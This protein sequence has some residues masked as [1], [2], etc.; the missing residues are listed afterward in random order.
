M[1]NKEAIEYLKWIR[2]I[3]PYSLDKIK[4]QESIDLAIKVLETGEVYMTGEDYNLYM[5]GYKAGKNDFGPKQG[6]WIDTG[7]G[8]EC[9]VCHEIQYGYDN[10]RYFCANCGAK[11]K[12]GTE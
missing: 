5:E 1:D 4:V 10:F 6:E 2:P 7:S 11:M 3:R 12:G 8:Q 9:S